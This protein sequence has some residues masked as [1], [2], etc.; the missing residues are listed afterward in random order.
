MENKEFTKLLFI[1][2]SLVVQMSEKINVLTLRIK[3]TDLKKILAGETV[4][5]EPVNSDHRV[6]AI[7]ILDD[8]ETGPESKKMVYFS[9]HSYWKMFFQ[10]AAEKKRKDPNSFK[11]FKEENLLEILWCLEHNANQKSV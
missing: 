2:R 10:R 5:Y 3:K 11:E 1:K 7:K 6:L 9:N 8:A 4:L